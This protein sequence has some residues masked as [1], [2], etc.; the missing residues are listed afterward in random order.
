MEVTSTPKRVAVVRRDGFRKSVSV[1]NGD[2]VDGEW[3][4]PSISERASQR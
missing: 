1:R 3:E 2:A 4:H